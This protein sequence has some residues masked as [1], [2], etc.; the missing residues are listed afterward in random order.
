V[1]GTARRVVAVAVAGLTA[2][3]TVPLLQAP[4]AAGPDSTRSTRAFVVRG[5]GFGH[6]HGMSQ[7]GAEGAARAGRSFRQILHFYYPHTTPARVGGW[8]RVLITADTSTDVTVLPARRLSV[9]DLADG[10]SWRLPTRAAHARKWRIVPKAGNAALSAVQ[11]RNASGWQRWNLPGRRKVLRGDGQF[12]ASGPIRLVLPDGSLRAYRGM[13]RSASPEPGSGTRDTVNVATFDQYVR[14]VLAAE[15]PSSWSRA[16]LKAQAVAA[17]SFAAYAR[18]AAGGSYW[19]VCDTT[20][21]Q[22]YG[23]VSA[24]TARTNRAV[25]GTARSILTF[26]GSP[27]LTQFSSSSGGWTSYGG[28]AYLPAKAD[29]YDAWSGNANHDWRMRVGAGVLEG[30]YA[31]LG[32]LRAVR[33]VKRDGHGEWGGRALQVRL[34]G[35]RGNVR[36]SGDDLRWVLGLPSTWFTAGPVRARG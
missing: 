6:G 30:A 4:A 14:G 15:M 12:G 36:L 33:V 31:G 1:T 28:M 3:A 19:Q 17:R 34:R 20:T 8:L 35:T 2:V 7:Y 16:A 22:V 5:H 11:Y 13:L 9:R 21:C 10:A 29:P 25:T 27:A 32:R 26:R 24:E 18:R 23:G